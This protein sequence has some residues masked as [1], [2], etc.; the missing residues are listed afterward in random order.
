MRQTDVS[1][2]E[3]LLGEGAPFY[4]VWSPRADKLLMHVGG[5]RSNS[6]QAHISLLENGNETV[7]IEL[8]LEPGRFQAPVWS[9]D[10]GHF[11]Y[12]AQNNDGEESIY[13]TNA[14]TLAQQPLT[15][16][17]GISFMI[18]SPDDQHLAFLQI[19]RNDGIPFG[20]AYII[21]TNGTQQ[22]L[23]TDKLVGSMYWSP[24][25]RKLAVLTVDINE[26]TKPTAKINGLALPLSQQI[27]FHWWLYDVA[28]K[29]FEPLISFEPTADFLQTIPFFDQYHL[30][31]TFWS[32]D[33]RYFVVTKRNSDKSQDGTVWVVDT[34]G[35]EEPRQVGEGQLAV[36]SWR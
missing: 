7:R 13:K 14:D 1:G 6:E 4:W 2:S 3:R 5:A 30:S 29:S 36:W 9:A 18:L 33:S 20:S 31:L 26:P 21:N 24:D 12:V 28:A 22:R 8:G 27:T 10:G 25:G 23:L 32:P 19:E 17:A 16:V 34:N 11:Y 35:Q 15:T